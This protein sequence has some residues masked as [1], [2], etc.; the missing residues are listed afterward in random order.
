MWGRRE[1]MH[2]LTLKPLRERSSFRGA[3][4]DPRIVP[5]PRP[6]F[7]VIGLRRGAPLVSALIR[8]CPM[9]IPQPTTVDGPNPDEWCRP[10]ED[11]PRRGAL[12][13]GKPVAIDRVRTTRS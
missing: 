6:G 7:Y 9:V 1:Q 5:R 4:E 11:S 12:I 13:D 10:L 2:V 8:L 3:W